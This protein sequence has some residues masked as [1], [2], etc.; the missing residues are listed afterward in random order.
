MDS[1][2]IDLK[3]IQCC[4]DTNMLL[5]DTDIKQI[6]SLGFSNNFFVD[7]FDGWLHLKNRDGRCVFHNGI[8]CLIYEDRPEGCRLYPITFDNDNNCAILDEEC[9]YR[10]KFLITQSLR[11]KLFHLIARIASERFQRMSGYND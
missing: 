1:L 11:K 2:C 4:K 9:P 7:T 8:K 6:K 5:S 10:T 3:C